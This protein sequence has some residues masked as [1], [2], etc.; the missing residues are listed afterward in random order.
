LAEALG[1]N[2]QLAEQAFADFCSRTDLPDFDYIALHGVWSWISDE[3]RAVIV[4]FLRRK[5][6]VGDVVYVSYNTQPGWATMMPMR[7]LLVE[8]ADI[9]GSQGQGSVSRFDSALGFAEELLATNPSYV[10]T[11]PNV[12]ERLAKLKNHSHSYLVHEYFNRNWQ[13]LSFSKTASLLSA[14]KLTFACSA[15]YLDHIDA[16]NLTTEQ[17]DLLND[18]PDSLFREMELVIQA[19]AFANKQL[20]IFMVLGICF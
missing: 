6:K 16:L 3:N 11:N 17:Q 7:D 1:S 20:P 4:D 10:Q 15:Y 8:H 18:I 14:A 13:P 2:A 19:H 12:S 5:L 9:M